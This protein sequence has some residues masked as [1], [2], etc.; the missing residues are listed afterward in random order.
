[1]IIE[2]IIIAIGF[3]AGMNAFAYGLNAFGENIK[4]GIKAVADALYYEEFE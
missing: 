2:S 1:M 4:E 3:V